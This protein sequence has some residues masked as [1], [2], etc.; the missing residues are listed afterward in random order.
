MDHRQRHR[1]RVCGVGSVARAAARAVT[2]ANDGP[3]HDGR[4]DA[5]KRLRTHGL[6]KKIGRTY[7]YYVTNFGKQVV[8]T[9][10]KLRELVIV[11]QLAAAAA[12]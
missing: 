11:P 6:I 9:A 2:N 12:R 3:A 7:K 4:P 5:G 8:A 10:L 1:R